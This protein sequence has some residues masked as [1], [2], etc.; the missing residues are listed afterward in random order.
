MTE[1]SDFE[2]VEQLGS[3]SFGKVM[4]VRSKK[5]QQLYVWKE[6]DY[7]KM[8]EK[9][10]QLIVSEV[11]I[12]RGL[13]HPH[14]VKYH[15][16]VLDRARKKL[17]IVMEC[18][19]GGD[20][21]QFIASLKKRKEYID[22]ATI[23]KIFS[24]ICSALKECHLRKGGKIIHR[25][26]KPANVLLDKNLNAK[27]GDFGLARMLSDNTK[28][29]HTKLGTPYYMSP[30][31]LSE[32][33]SDQGYNESCD[34]WSLGCMLYELCALEPPFKAPNGV[35]LEKKILAGKYEPIPSQYSR[36]LSELI[37]SMLRINPEKRI[38]I[39][40]ICDSTIM[41]YPLMETHLQQMYKI[42]K[43]KEKALEKREQFVRKKEEK[44]EEL[45]KQLE[46][47]KRE[48]E[49]LKK[50][51]V[52]NTKAPIPPPIEGALVVSPLAMEVNK[53]NIFQTFKV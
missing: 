53:E 28:L 30:E 45:E 41:K 43:D 2:I 42:L 22:E 15:N 33:V 39:A 7:S 47:E 13:D 40:E 11:N 18:C 50:G 25:D 32:H 20:L 23:L 3:G 9:E 37:A 17:Y 10:K 21:S 6:I 29:A 35:L 51:N 16:R 36:E 26:L 52:V 46:K 5:D 27:L 44:L 8:S 34:I 1:L 4:K 49:K 14:I 19:E 12:L 31:L 24:E 48:L 38:T